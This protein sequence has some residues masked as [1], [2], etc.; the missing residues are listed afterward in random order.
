MPREE[1]KCAEPVNPIQ[2]R[3]EARERERAAK[4]PLTSK[5]LE[6]KM[7]DAEERRKMELEA[8]KYKGQLGSKPAPSWPQQAPGSPSQLGQPNDTQIFCRWSRKNI[9]NRK[10]V[11]ISL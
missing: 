11:R 2:A 7:A 5:D 4:K 8:I 3:L 9:K 10:N 6:N 1:S